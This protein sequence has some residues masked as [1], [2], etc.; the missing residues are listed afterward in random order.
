MSEALFY[1]TCYSVSPSPS[2]DP[3]D[4]LNTQNS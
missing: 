2:I 3:S 1:L 4:M